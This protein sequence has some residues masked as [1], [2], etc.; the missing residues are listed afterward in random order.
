MYYTSHQ[1]NELTLF[2]CTVCTLQKLQIK[3]HLLYSSDRLYSL[4]DFHKT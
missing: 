1:F 3:Y 4:I 2:E